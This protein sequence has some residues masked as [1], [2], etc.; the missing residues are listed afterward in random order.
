[1]KP[2]FI[3][4]EHSQG[5]TLTFYIRRDEFILDPMECDNIKQAKASITAIREAAKAKR[6]FIVDD[7]KGNFYIEMRDADGNVIATSHSYTSRYNAQKGIEALEIYIPMAR[8]HKVTVEELD[9]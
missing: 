4:D 3:I 9:V 1:M 5:A 2:D 8:A 7:C 6:Y